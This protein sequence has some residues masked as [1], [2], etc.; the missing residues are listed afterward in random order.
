MPLRFSDGTFDTEFSECPCCLT[1][2]AASN[3]SCDGKRRGL[4]DRCTAAITPALRCDR[5][6]DHLGEHDCIIEGH[7]VTWQPWSSAASRSDDEVLV[8]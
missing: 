8:S 7:R 1:Y 6:A 3:L 4:G 2:H 5:F